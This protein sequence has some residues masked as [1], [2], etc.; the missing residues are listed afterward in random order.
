MNRLL[1]TTSPPPELTPVA[2][3]PY[4]VEGMVK[5]QIPEGTQSGTV[6][7]LRGKGVPTVGSSARGDQYVKI[8]VEVPTRLS[9]RQRGLLEDFA[10]EGGIEVSPKTKSFV[11]KL[12][13]LFD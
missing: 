10:E 11:D 8:F 2:T 3:M 13:D 12:R 6:L 1:R 9:D 4:M 5:M 7:R